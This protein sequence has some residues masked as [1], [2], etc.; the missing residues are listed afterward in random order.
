MRKALLAIV[1]LAAFPIALHAEDSAK[2]K[3]AK[4]EVDRDLPQR[5]ERAALTLKLQSQPRGSQEWTDTKKQI[6]AKTDA[7][8][9]VG[10]VAAGLDA[11]DTKALDDYYYDVMKNCPKES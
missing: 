7:V 8:H 11:E 4:A 1:V 10:A 9:G 3:A 2:L 6:K 5:C